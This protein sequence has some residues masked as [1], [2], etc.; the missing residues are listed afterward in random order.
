M[1]LSEK[2][3]AHAAK[4]DQV[5]AGEIVT[6]DLDWCMSNDATTHVSID[7]FENKV[8]NKRIADPKKTVFILD[9]N[10]PSESVKTTHVQNKMRKF[11]REH[12]IHLHDGEGVCHQILL[13]LQ[14]QWVQL[15]L[16]LREDPCYRYFLEVQI[17][18][19]SLGDQQ[20]LEHLEQRGAT[21]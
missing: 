9:H 2:I 16:G 3:L 20:H 18:Q 11:A 7:I 15:V 6:V 17:G 21:W 12:G 5:S 14:T 8:Q 1:T 4:K 13:V 10:V 19:V